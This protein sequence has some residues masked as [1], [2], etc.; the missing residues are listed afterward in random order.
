MQK[1][2]IR[3]VCG[4][5][6]IVDVVAVTSRLMAASPKLK[7]S[8]ATT[9]TTTNATPT[10]RRRLRW[11]RLLPPL[12]SSWSQLRTTCLVDWSWSW[13]DVRLLARRLA[14][15]LSD[16]QLPPQ[17]LYSRR[18]RDHQRQQPASE[19][20]GQSVGSSRPSCR[21]DRPMESNSSRHQPAELRNNLLLRREFSPRFN[22]NSTSTTPAT[23]S[24]FNVQLTLTH[25]L[26][27]QLE[28][29]DATEFTNQL[30]AHQP[31]SG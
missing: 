24:P 8:R 29:R 26:T 17:L 18:H 12:L 4:C 31:T 27:R 28:S 14:C 30:T 9:A 7:P 2:E 21:G 16:L 1:A 10:R 3:Q 6:V 15:Q 19:Q 5:A 20:V 22:E 25:S 23:P 13:L 11:R